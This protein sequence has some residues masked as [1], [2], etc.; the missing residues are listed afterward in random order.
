MLY[1]FKTLNSHLNYLTNWDSFVLMIIVNDK[2][3]QGWLTQKR[4]CSYLI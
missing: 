1:S 2:R 4:D 3:L